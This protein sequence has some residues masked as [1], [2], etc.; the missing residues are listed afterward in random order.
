MDIIIDNKIRN[1]YG[2]GLKR[3]KDI[4]MVVLH[5]TGGGGTYNY[6]LNNTQR[7][8]QYKKS[9]GLFH[10][11]IE[12]SGQTIE[13]I[14]PDN[15]TYHSHSNYFDEETIGIELVNMTA[16][17]SGFITDMQYSSLFRLIIDNLFP[18]YPI[19]DIVGHSYL[20]EKYMRK[21]K[22]DPPCPGKG[23][24]WTKLET[25][26]ADYGFVFKSV[27]GGI[28]NIKFEDEVTND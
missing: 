19:D 4:T 22:T 6:I 28:F 1:K 23:F 20:Y 26:L 12:R 10:Y 13:I 24:D 8:E 5:C 15:W 17:N 27:L 3:S 11:L 25:E 14:S 9:I 2:N 16:D 21:V 18:Q 7:A